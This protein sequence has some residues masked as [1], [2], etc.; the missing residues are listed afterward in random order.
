MH[1]HFRGHIRHQ[2]RG[3]RP[4]RGQ[5]QNDESCTEIP[6]RRSGRAFGHGRHH[7]GGRLGRVFAHGDLRFVI[8]HLVAAK[9]R[10][11]YEIIKEIE[12]M[13]GGAYTP[14]P[15]TIYPALTLL[16]ELGHVTA[17]ATDGARKLYAITEDG[18]AHLA[19]N[20]GA[21][22]D[23]LARMERVRTERKRDM[24]PPIVEAMARLQQAVA[25]AGGDQALT[26]DQITR[27]VAAIDNATIAVNAI[28]PTPSTDTD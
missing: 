10:H 6:G 19:R 25:Q 2:R 8:L 20:Q 26:E 12:T 7:G 16:E 3:G 15:G 14:S 27:I 9:P 24:P 23:L 1:D 22:D 21:I 5:A 13:V 18:V 17:Q 11:G 28:E 4:H